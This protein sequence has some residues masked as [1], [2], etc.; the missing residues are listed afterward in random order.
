VDIAR[1]P[2]GKMVVRIIKFNLQPIGYAL[3]MNCAGA[4]FLVAQKA[5]K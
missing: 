5:V 4:V 2:D 3:K 1:G